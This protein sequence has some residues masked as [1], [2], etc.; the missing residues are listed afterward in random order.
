MSC[1]I[2]GGT[3]QN[4]DIY[5]SCGV[6]AEWANLYNPEACCIAING[7]HS[8]RCERQPSEDMIHCWC[9]LRDNPSGWTGLWSYKGYRCFDCEGHP[10]VGLGCGG[11]SGLADSRSAGI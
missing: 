4:V 3:V 2:C 11:I 1:R 6:C 9:C 10:F 8:N 5:G 7:S